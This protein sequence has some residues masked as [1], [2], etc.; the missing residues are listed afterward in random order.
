MS[1]EFSSE[2][3]EL[4]AFQEKAVIYGWVAGDKKYQAGLA[5]IEKKWKAKGKAALATLLGKSAQ[6]AAGA[7][8]NEWDNRKYTY[9]NWYELAKAVK[10]KDEVI[11]LLNKHFKGANFRSDRR[12]PGSKGTFRATCE[13][14]GEDMTKLWKLE[15]KK[16]MVKDGYV[17]GAILPASGDDD[18]DEE[19]EEEAS[20]SAVPENTTGAGASA[21]SSPGSK[22]C[23]KATIRL[24]EVPEDP[25]KAKHRKSSKKRA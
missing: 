12:A 24:G 23:R 21:D 18:D 17:K 20:G 7:D 25:A 8:A 15:N 16:L 5:L 9:G 19:E 10:D 4:R 11:P 2:L 6:G 22:R 1:E 14:D 13:L 3:E